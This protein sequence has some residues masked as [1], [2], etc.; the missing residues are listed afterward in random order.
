MRKKTWVITLCGTVAVITASSALLWADSQNSEKTGVPAR[1]CSGT[2]SGSMVEPL[3]TDRDGEM[4]TEEDERFPGKFHEFRGDELA[5]NLRIND[6]D[7]SIR[8]NQ[9]SWQEPREK[10]LRRRKYVVELGENYGGYLK[11]HGVMTLGVPCPTSKWKN[12]YLTVEVEA[13]SAAQKDN[14][15][16]DIRKQ[17]GHLANLTGY[18][19]RVLAGKVYECKGAAEIPDGPVQVRRGKGEW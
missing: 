3:F 5:C 15:G 17:T 1:V 9:P 13:D 18:V 12:G 4:G 11:D 2:F 16:K 19:T 6:Y 10:N 7:V 14:L 8:V